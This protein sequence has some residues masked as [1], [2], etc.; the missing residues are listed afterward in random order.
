MDVLFRDAREADAP[1]VFNILRTVL[2]GY[3]LQANPEV[4]DK[5]L[6]DIKAYY[7]EAGGCFRVVEDNGVVIGSY[8][9]FPISEHGCELR[10]MYLLPDY[11]GLGIG[12]KMMDEALTLA[13]EKGFKEMVLETNTVLAKAT[14]LYQRYGFREYE[15]EH[16]SD[17]CDFAMKKQ[18]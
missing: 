18:L 14:R 4:T 7:V 8:G 9:L 10:K 17:R 6:S 12:K 2:Q 3:G 15:P 1:D 11:Q 16:L 13:R 5:D